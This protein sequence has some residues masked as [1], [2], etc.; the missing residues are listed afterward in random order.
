LD[1]TLGRGKSYSDGS[2]AKKHG[3][4]MGFHGII[5]GISWDYHGIYPVF[6]GRLLK[7]GCNHGEFTPI[8]WDITFK[9]W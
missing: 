8:S 3:G 9:L 6:G 7:D 5:M 4:F 1:V 2:S